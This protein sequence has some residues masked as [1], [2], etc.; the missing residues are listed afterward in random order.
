MRKIVVAFLFL[1]LLF[2]NSIYGQIY[3]RQVY[4]RFGG[5]ATKRFGGDED[6]STIRALADLSLGYYFSP[7]FSMEINGGYG[8]NTIRDISKS[9][10]L[11][12][13]ISENDSLD[14]KTVLYPISLNL[15]YNFL[16]GKPVIPFVIGGLGYNFWE[17]H[18]S[19]DDSSITSERNFM[20]LLGT[21]LEFQLSRSLALDISIR[22]HNFFDQVKD[23]SG[24]EQAGLAPDIS[25]G[26]FSVGMGFSIRLG[27]WLDS[28]GDG[29]EDRQDKRPFQAEDFD[30]FQDEDGCPDPDNDGDG[31]L[32]IVE[33]N[34]GIFVSKQD[35]GS[36]PNDIDT[37]N[38][39]LTDYDEVY[40]YGTDPNK[41]DTDGDGLSDY[42]E[43]HVYGTD[44]TLTDTDRD[45]LNDYEE[46]FEYFTDPLNPDT[47]GD[48]FVDGRDKCPLEPET[49]NGY[50]DDDGCPD[51][52]PD[53]LLQKRTPV[54][55]EGIQFASGSA[56]LTDSAKSKIQKML[57]TL[58][59]YPEIH[60]EIS[61][62][63]DNTG[64][65]SANIKLS[66][67]RAEAV[68]NYLISEGIEPNRLRAIGLG[69]DYPIA[70]NKTKEGRARNRRI[71]FY[72]TK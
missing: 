53:L 44:P 13:H 26:N 17:I 52:K 22:Y 42:D 47:D 25:E 21:G 56:K 24:V 68:R 62:H 55:L 19:A 35:T 5:Y 34:T 7:N 43:I 70:S 59:D 37:D 39:G 61:G 27:G 8:Y 63:T 1:L 32:D 51:E 50:K 69:P 9:G 31:L 30:G 28:D 40:I 2:S 72:R 45:L 64:S 15:R 6:L 36:N 4:F 33:T 23:M 71:E 65:R 49:Y 14:F 18:D 12:S 66:K 41:I 57:I 11:Q 54:I 46:I 16:R 58:K 10:W 38:D 29:I 48:G 67:A 3:E 60:L 20:A